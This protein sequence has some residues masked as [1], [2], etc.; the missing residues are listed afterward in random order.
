MKE[1]DNTER[2]ILEEL[3]ELNE[4]LK[5][6]CADAEF[7]HGLI[8]EWAD[9]HEDEEVDKM[10]IEELKRERERGMALYSRLR[11]SV[12][13]M[14]KIDSRYNEIRERVN[15]Y[16]GKDIPP[17]FPPASIWDEILGDFR[18]EGEGG[19]WKGI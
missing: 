1:E 10:G 18:G 5:L 4:A 16:Y 13:E 11:I 2:D 15:K 6:C 3:E 8:C 9:R 17:L 7:T 19:E 12:G 14:K